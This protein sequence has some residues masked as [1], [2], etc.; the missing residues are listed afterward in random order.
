VLHLGSYAS[1]MNRNNGDAVA[2]ERRPLLDNSV[3]DTSY[4]STQNGHGVQE[5][6]SPAESTLNKLSKS[7][8]RWIM[9]GLWSAS[10]TKSII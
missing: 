7:D 10:E 9:A 4:E 6:G 1:S 8:L 5:P 3:P 2:S